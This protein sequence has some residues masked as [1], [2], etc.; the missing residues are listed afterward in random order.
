MFSRKPK[1]Y[2]ILAW[3]L[4]GAIIILSL[5][6]G[7]DLPT[8]NWWDHIQVDKIGHILFYGA[9][10]WCFNKYKLEQ[11]DPSRISFIYI[12][13]ILMGIALEYFQEIM[14][15]GRQFDVFDVVANSFGVGL[16]A[17]IKRP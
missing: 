8:L 7:N 5:L 4:V 10:A 16:V 15:L 14:Q 3:S 12:A 11:A 6:P 17:F 9:T 1:Y 2:F 13:L